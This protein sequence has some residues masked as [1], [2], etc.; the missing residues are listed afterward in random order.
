MSV[1][2]YIHVCVHICGGQTSMLVV[3]LNNYLHY[4]I[5]IIIYIFILLLYNWDL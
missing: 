1:Q 5:N 4:I 3:F 2:V